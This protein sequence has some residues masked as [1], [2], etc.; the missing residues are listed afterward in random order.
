METM[1]PVLNWSKLKEVITV[2]IIWT[3][4]VTTVIQKKQQFLEVT[5]Q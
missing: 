1:R 5:G 2:L 3:W 4:V